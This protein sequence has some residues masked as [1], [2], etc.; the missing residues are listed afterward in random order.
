M[1]SKERLK[2]KEQGNKWVV[3]IPESLQKSLAAQ[4]ALGFRVSY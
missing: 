4:P 3:R 2:W 1:G